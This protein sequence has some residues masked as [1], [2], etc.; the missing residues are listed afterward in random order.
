MVKSYAYGVPNFGKGS[1][2]K[3]LV[4]YPSCPDCYLQLRV[5]G[6]EAVFKGARTTH[7]CIHSL[8]DGK[9]CNTELT[10]SIFKQ[11]FSTGCI[12]DYHVK[13]HPASNVAK[14]AEAA[15]SNKRR[16][17]DSA[18]QN[19]GKRP[20]GVAPRPAVGAGR[21]GGQLQGSLE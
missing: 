19:A 4:T 9:S 1:N 13:P 6:S 15:L 7:M 10:L 12:A 3:T 16:A 14:A 8:G 11:S 17:I 21:Q 20:A 18:M 5:P 2:L